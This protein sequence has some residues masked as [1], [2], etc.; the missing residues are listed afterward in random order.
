MASLMVVNAALGLLI[1]DVDI[2]KN[3]KYRLT[4]RRMHMILGWGT[5]N[6]G[7]IN[8][9][10]GI[11]DLTVDADPYNIGQHVLWTI[12]GTLVVLVAFVHPL[13]KKKL[14]ERRRLKKKVKERSDG[15]RGFEIDGRFLP[16]FTWDEV[17]IRI[18]NGAHWIIVDGIICNVELF[19]KR[20]PSGGLILASSYGLEATPVYTGSKSACI[21][22]KGAGS[23]ENTRI[24]DIVRSRYSHS[25]I[26]I[27]TLRGLSVGVL[28]SARTKVIDND[29]IVPQQFVPVTLKK[30]TLETPRGTS[31]IYVLELEYPKAK[32]NLDAEPGDAVYLRIA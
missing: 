8:C 23:N 32:W 19:R 31:L 26:A 15:A 21:Y 22:R 4:L 5:W 24:V 13:L 25:R 14:A 20:H 17:H 6:L 11:H 1:K 2:V 12:A 27:S 28:E 29:T 30:K 9:S 7:M 3:V 16:Y 10:I 18:E